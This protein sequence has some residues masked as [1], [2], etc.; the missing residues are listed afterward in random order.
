MNALPRILF[1]SVLC[2]AVSASAGTARDI[3]LVLSSGGCKGAYHLGVWRALSEA[4]LADR[5][6]VISGTSVGALCSA[7]FACVKDCDRQEE[8]WKDSVSIFQ[9]TP[10]RADVE[11]IFEREAAKKRQWYGVAE[12]STALTNDLWI[13]ALLQARKE[14]MPKVARAY[15]ELE[16][17]PDATNLT[18]G[19]FS[20]DS[21]RRNLESCLPSQ[22]AKDDPVVYA[23]ALK[24]G[25]ERLLK[26]FCINSL[27]RKTQI[28]ALCASA[29]IPVAFSP[30][31]IDGALWQDGG[32]TERGGDKTP[33]DPILKNHKDVK[34][35]IVVYLHDEK[36]LPLGYRNEIRRKADAAGVRLLEIVPTRNIGG[37]FFGWVG[38]FD[39]TP[40]TMQNLID[41]G[42]RDA[43]GMLEKEGLIKSAKG[44]TQ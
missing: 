18:F 26:S 29:A 4:G 35:V 6:G 20:T 42:Y 5:I 7:L 32:W 38:V 36:N 3:G 39:S 31:E 12:L 13:A 37:P 11:R 43:K 17:D 40:E 19:V 15:R 33:I 28:D 14:M 25:K 16:T 27:D 8:I 34:I 1:L 2:A 30:I 41:A 24:C 23:T 21:L 9:L 44:G 22:F 10:E